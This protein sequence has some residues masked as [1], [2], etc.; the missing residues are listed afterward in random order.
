M[1]VQEAKEFLRSI[2]SEQLEIVHLKNLMSEAEMG[3]MMPKAIQYDKDRVQVSPEDR[4]SLMCAKIA[5]Y[6]M[7]I[8]QSIVTLYEKRLKAEQ[9]I[10]KLS[11]ESEREVLRWYYLTSEDG[12][13]LT[14]GQV[15]MR[16][17]YSER[18]IKRLHGEALAHLAE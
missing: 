9:M 1:T 3:V 12:Y 14:W 4:Y 10:K 16:M 13:L 17:N 2:R 6:Q 11:D 7:E 15:A 8:G 5:D 18:Q